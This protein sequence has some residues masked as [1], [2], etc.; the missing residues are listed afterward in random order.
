M[1]RLSERDIITKKIIPSL[2][3]AGWDITNQVMEE[4][5]FTDGRI[6]VRGKKTAKGVFKL[7]K[8]LINK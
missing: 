7:G 3:N 6:K 4:V 1:S 5:Y 2:K 8:W